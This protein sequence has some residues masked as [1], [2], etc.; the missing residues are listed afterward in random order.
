MITI[1]TEV[2]KWGN[3]MAIIL[4]KDK[5]KEAHIKSGKKITILIPDGVI[6]LRKDFGSLKHLLKKPT[7][8][9]KNELRKEEFE[10]EQR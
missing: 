3:S 8:E 4:P 7:Q 6:N 10:I 9:I 2:R 1:E 5:A